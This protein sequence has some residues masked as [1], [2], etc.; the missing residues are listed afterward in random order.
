ML[1]QLLLLLLM[2]VLMIYLIDAAVDPFAEDAN[3]QLLHLPQPLLVGRLVLEHVPQQNER[4]LLHDQERT[5][6]R[7]HL[8]RLAVA[9]LLD[10]QNVVDAL[11]VLSD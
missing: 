4:R 11:E 6:D 1:Q 5:V 7:V 9:L 2:L 10:S 3:G 8:P